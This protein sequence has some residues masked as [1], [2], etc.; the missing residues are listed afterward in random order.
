M[1]PT[2]SGDYT[3]VSTSAEY[4]LGF[5]TTI[6]AAGEDAA[7]EYIFGDRGDMELI[8]V[9]NDSGS[10]ISA[11]E[12]VARKTNT[13]G[14]YVRTSPI[15]A[16][17]STLV[18]MALYDIGDDEYGFI[19][20]RGKTDLL[21]SDAADLRNVNL[22]TG[23]VAGRAYAQAATDAIKGSIGQGAFNNGAGA[24]GESGAAFIDL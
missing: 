12:L 13:D 6:P 7:D 9:F 14:Y 22:A 2:L 21:N 16:P 3:Q 4:P 8:Y 11:G 20:K 24:G 17:K 10:T 5:R 15:N 18:G 1:Q 23:A 19:L